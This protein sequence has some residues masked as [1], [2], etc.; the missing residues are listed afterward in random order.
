MIVEEGT[1]APS[2]ENHHMFNLEPS[3]HYMYGRTHTD[4][5]KQKIS[6]SKKG[7]KSWNSGKTMCDNFK[8]TISETWS[9]DRRKQQSKRF[10]G[11]NHPMFG[12][13]QSEETKQKIAE[14][15]RKRKEQ[16]A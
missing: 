3:A 2:G 1:G 15:L 16:Q 14:S 10:S 8:L 11:E 12:R 6:E 13:K 7:K 5:A 4:E 9:D